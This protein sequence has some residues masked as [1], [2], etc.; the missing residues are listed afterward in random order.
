VC[1]GVLCQVVVA[2]GFSPSGFP[3]LLGPVKVDY[4]GTIKIADAAMDAKVRKLV[5]GDP[6]L[7]YAAS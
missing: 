5:R 3:D 4:A 6:P 1:C 7:L 2:T